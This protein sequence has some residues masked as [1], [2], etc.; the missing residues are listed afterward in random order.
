[1]RDGESE[2]VSESKRENKRKHTTSM[3]QKQ[4]TTIVLVWFALGVDEG[5]SGKENLVES[6]SAFG[7]RGQVTKCVSEFV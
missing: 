4:T 7:W 6:K 3:K 2:R 1:M 5:E